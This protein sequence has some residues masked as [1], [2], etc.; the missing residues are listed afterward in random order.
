MLFVLD[1]VFYSF[2]A[3]IQTFRQLSYSVISDCSAFSHSPLSLYAD[4]ED[5]ILLLNDYIRN[6][7]LISVY[8]VLSFALSLH[9]FHPAPLRQLSVCSL[10]L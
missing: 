2:H 7:T 10:Y 6:L 1:P 8:E 3:S 4:L 5:I 9:P